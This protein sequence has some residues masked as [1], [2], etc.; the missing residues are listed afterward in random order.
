MTVQKATIDQRPTLF[1][2]HSQS[3]DQTLDKKKMDKMTA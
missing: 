3:C 2:S 1:S